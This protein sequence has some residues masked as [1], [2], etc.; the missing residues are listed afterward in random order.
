MWFLCSLYRNEYGNLQL[1][2]ATRERE[3]GRSEETGRDKPIGV[4]MYMYME[5]SQGISLCSYLYLKLAK[6]AMF[7]ILFCFLFYKI[8]EQEGRIDSV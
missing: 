5:T 3:L 6:P 1:A 8:R 7:L 2:M 4:V